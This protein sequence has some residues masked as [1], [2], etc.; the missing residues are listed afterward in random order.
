MLLLFAEARS[1]ASLRAVA[2][3]TAST[4]F[5][6][7]A[8]TMGAFSSDY[9]RLMVSGL[10]FCWI[11]DALLLRL[12]RAAFLAGM[13]A[14]AIGHLLY[15]LAFLRVGA[16]FG[17]GA[18]AAA[19]LSTSGAAAAL[20]WLKPHLGAMRAPVTAYSLLIAMMVVLAI[21]A[22]LTRPALTMAA[23]GAV[24]FALSDLA[25][26]RDQFVRRDFFN[27]AWGLPL[28]YFSQCLLAAS[29]SDV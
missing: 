19:I 27:R 5:V 2:K 28:Y 3:M 6:A 10:I 26:A 23:V 13:G 12:A 15:S 8:V 14:F 9:G 24:G 25:V 18:F 1:I 29:I 11:G 4:A 16:D 17:A 22:A 21:A 7:L 20:V